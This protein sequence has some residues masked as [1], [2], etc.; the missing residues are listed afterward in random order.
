MSVIVFEEFIARKTVRKEIL[1]T[2]MIK[3][4]V[5]HSIFR[6]ISTSLFLVS[7]IESVVFGNS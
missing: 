5:D 2:Q 3:V 4:V 6:M 1:K 7:R